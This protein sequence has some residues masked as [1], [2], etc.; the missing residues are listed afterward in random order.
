MKKFLVA[1]VLAAGIGAIAYA[2][3]SKT[4]S[5]KQAIEKKTEKKEKKKECKKKCIFS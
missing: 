1:L 2:S 5:N 3:L 4:S